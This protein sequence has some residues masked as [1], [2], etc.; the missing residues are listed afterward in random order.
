MKF[1]YQLLSITVL[2]VLIV[3]CQVKPVPIQYGADA[4]VFCKMN[5]VDNQHAAELVTNK[6]KVFKYDAIEC[7]INDTTRNKASDIALYLVNDYSKPGNLTDATKASYLIS[8]SIPSPMGA[9]LSAF[10]DAAAAHQ[11]QNKY[12][13]RVYSW[14][15]IQTTIKN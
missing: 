4:C 3:G 5:I 12:K 14:T 2:S 9:Y 11:A 8:E 13:G 1:L 6:G 15:T 7:M 10:G